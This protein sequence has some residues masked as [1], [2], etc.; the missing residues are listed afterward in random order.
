MPFNENYSYRTLGASS[1]RT[2]AGKRS[3]RNTNMDLKLIFSLLV[4]FCWFSATTSSPGSKFEAAVLLGS[5][6]N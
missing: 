5:L 3:Q 4:V 2:R 6:L 1:A